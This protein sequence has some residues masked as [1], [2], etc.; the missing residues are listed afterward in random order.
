[1]TTPEAEVRR[2]RKIEV[3]VSDEVYRAW[4]RVQHAELG[5]GNVKSG[6]DFV[7]MLLHDH[8]VQGRALVMRGL[9]A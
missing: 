6:E 2:S 3:R 9:S 8:E 4:K 1:M 7:K 5:E